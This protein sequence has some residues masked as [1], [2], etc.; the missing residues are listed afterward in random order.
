MVLCDFRAL[1]IV[2]G[3][4]VAAPKKI[5]TIFGSWA[6]PNMP[7]SRYQPRGCGTSTS[8]DAVGGVTVVVAAAVLA[9]LSFSRMQSRSKGPT[10]T[11]ANDAGRNFFFSKIFK[12]F[13]ISIFFFFFKS[14]S[15]P[16]DFP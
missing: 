16:V 8:A 7:P 14:L 9:G 10:L 11:D 12:F 2:R 1:D 3:V 4:W 15:I 5:F 6:L 13:N